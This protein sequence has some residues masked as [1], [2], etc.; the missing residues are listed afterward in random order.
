MAEFQVG[1][2]SEGNTLQAHQDYDFFCFEID[3][4][5]INLGE[6]TALASSETSQEPLHMDDREEAPTQ[7]HAF[8]DSQT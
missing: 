7:K 5:G 8:P 3:C 2:S 6:Q 4:S 1:L